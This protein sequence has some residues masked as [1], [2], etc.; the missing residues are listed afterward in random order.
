MNLKINKIAST[1]FRFIAVATELIP[2]DEP[3]LIK[4]INCGGD[5]FR[6]EEYYYV[7]KGKPLS[8]YMV[9][10]SFGEFVLPDKFFKRFD[11]SHGI[12]FFLCEPMEKPPE[13]VKQPNQ[14]EFKL[15]D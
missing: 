13:P 14:E 2:E 9:M 12:I 15:F 5:H 7:E 8:M 6:V 3:S 4:T 10:L 1:K 11:K